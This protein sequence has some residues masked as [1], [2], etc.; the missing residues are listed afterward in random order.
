MAASVMPPQRARERRASR[1][2]PAPTA[3]SSAWLTCTPSNLRLTSSRIR[4]TSRQSRLPAHT[5][6]GEA[7]PASSHASERQQPDKSSNSTW[8]SASGMPRST[9][10]ASNDAAP[11]GRPPSLLPHQ[12]S[13]RAKGG[14]S[15][16]EHA[17][18]APRSGAAPAPPSR[19]SASLSSPPQPSCPSS[20]P[21]MECAARKSE[22][23]CAG[24]WSS[25]TRT[26]AEPNAAP[27]TGSASRSSAGQTS[28]SVNRPRAYG[29][30]STSIC[31]ASR[32]ASQRR[33]PRRHAESAHAEACGG[34]AG[35]ERGKSEMGPRAV[36]GATRDPS[37]F[38]ASDPSIS[39]AIDR[40]ISG[41]GD[42]SIPSASDSARHAG[43][44]VMTMSWVEPLH[45][46]STRATNSPGRET[47]AEI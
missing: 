13:A 1:G 42:L 22:Y 10:A 38:G 40:S 43:P 16:Q 19:Y 3:L 20:P 34:T 5:P 37:S 14:R 47:S 31:L 44:R 9:T 45:A 4:P 46:S 33:Y 7:S 39:G 15:R 6:S 21:R 28:R 32:A 29:S 11:Q 18:C 26:R 8:P 17:P 25:H 36:S 35:E 12:T 24:I 23:S 41:A 27:S 2:S 30:D